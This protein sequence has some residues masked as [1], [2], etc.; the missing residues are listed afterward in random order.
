M[1][2]SV[3]VKEQ[4]ALEPLHK[5]LKVHEQHKQV[6]PMEKEITVRFPNSTLI[7]MVAHHN[8]NI[9]NNQKVRLYT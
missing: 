2:Y 6:S 1:Y 7:R 4:L 5:E 9:V 8:N 3:R